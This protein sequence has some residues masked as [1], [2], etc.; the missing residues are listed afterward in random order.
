MANKR[1][2]TPDTAGVARGTSLSERSGYRFGL[3]WETKRSEVR[4]GTY[5]YPPTADAGDIG[6]V[7]ATVAVVAVTDDG[8]VALSDFPYDP[9]GGAAS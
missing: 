1:S 4:S 2:E 7:S 3:A 8:W 9:F 6:T 5:G